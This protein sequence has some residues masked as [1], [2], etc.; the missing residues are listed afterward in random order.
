MTPRQLRTFISILLGAL[1]TLTA[2]SDG[3]GNGPGGAPLAPLTLELPAVGT[4]PPGMVNG[5]TSS[6]AMFN[7]ELPEDSL[8]SDQITLRVIDSAGNVVTL[9]ANGIDGGG[10]IS[11]GPADLSGLTDGSLSVTAMVERGGSSSGETPL[12]DIELD[13]LPPLAPDSLAIPSI[14]GVP[15]DVVATPNL[16]QVAVEMGRTGAFAGDE[17]FR[18]QFSDGVNI[19]TI[20]LFGPATPGAISLT[21]PVG[22]LSSL[23]DGLI[24]VE[25]T[26]SDDA[27]NTVVVNK[28]G[29]IK[30]TQAPAL[31]EAVAIAA[32][33]SNGPNELNATNAGDAE[34]DVTWP[35]AAS[36]DDEVTFTF[37]AGGVSV[38]FGPLS[39]LDGGG[40]QTLGPIDLSGLPDGTVNISYEARDPATNAASGVGTPATKSAGGLI[41]PSSA[42]VAA[43]TDN[44]ADI[45]NAASQNMAAVTVILPAAYDGSEQISVRLSD[46]INPD[47]N[48]GQLSSAPG[49]GQLNF[50]GLDV[51]GL[52][53]GPLALTV[54]VD[55]GAGPVNF[56]GDM[57]QKDT[58]A[59]ALPSAAGLAAG[60]GNAANEINNTNLTN[61]VVN[62]VLD[63]GMTGDE[64]VSLRLQDTGGTILP[65]GPFPIAAGGGSANF[66]PL[67]LSPLGDGSISIEVVVHDPAGNPG[68]FS[69]S[70]ANKSTAGPDAPSAAMVIAG[71]GNAAN[72]INQSNLNS[73]QVAVTLPATTQATDII[74]VTLSD[75]VA[76]AS[77][78]PVNSPGSPGAFTIG[79]IDSTGLQDG[80]IA[81]MVTIDDGA[82][83]VTGFTGTTAT[84]DATGPTAPL[85]AFV[86]ASTSNP[87]NFINLATQAA[88]R[89]D[90]FLDS[91]LTASDTVALTLSDGAITIGPFTQNAL[92]GGGILSFTGIDATTLTPG[93]VSLGIVLADAGA[94]ETPAMGSPAT[95]DIVA[96][97]APT[98]SFVAAGTD[99]PQDFVN[100]ANEGMTSIEVQIPAS[101]VGGEMVSLAINDGINP[102]VTTLEVSAPA[103][104]TTMLFSG[105]DLS[106]LNDGSLT[107]VFQGRDGAGNLASF[108]GTPATKDTAAPDAPSAL[109]VAAGAQNGASIINAFNEPSTTLDITWPA[110][111][112]GD[113]TANVILSSDGGGSLNFGTPVPAGGGTA[114]IGPFAS[115]PL[116]DGNVSLTIEITDPAGNLTSFTG[117]PALK[118][119]APATDPLT[120]GVSAGPQNP[121]NFIN[122][123]TRN[124]VAV[125]VVL[126]ASAEAT[127]SVTVTL[128]DSAMTPTAVTAAQNP[129]AGGGTLSFAGIDASGLIDGSCAVNVR[130]VD[131][132][133]NVTDYVG[134]PAL[135]DTAA[136]T[137]ASGANVAAT[138]N[139]PIHFVN[140]T[141]EAAV[142]AEAAL[143]GDLVGDETVT[144]IFDDG[145]NPA[146]T[147]GGF[148]ASAGGGTQ[149]E[150]A[151][152][153]VA[154]DEGAIQVTVVITDPAGNATPFFGTSAT[155]DVSA[156]LVA[157]ASNIP[158]SVQNPLNVVNDNIDGGVSFDVVWDNSMIGD[159]SAT[160]TVTSDGGAGSATLGPVTPPAN[161]GPQTIGP[162]DLSALPDGNLTIAYAIED[163]A[164]NSTPFNASPAAKDTTAPDDPTAANVIAGVSNPVHFINIASESSATVEVSLGAGAVAT[165]LIAVSLIDGGMTATP[166][167]ATQNA[168]SGGGSLSFGPI[169]TITLADGPVTVSVQLE[170][171]NGNVKTFN[172][173]TATKDTGLPASIDASVIAATSDNPEGFINLTTVAGVSVS[174]DVPASY[175]SADTIRVRLDDG[176]NQTSFT[177]TQSPTGGASETLTFPG[178][179]ASGLNDGTGNINIAVEVVEASG[180]TL[181]FSGSSGSKD[182]VLPDSPVAFGV[183]AGAMN[184]ADFINSN[185]EGATILSVTWG[186]AQETDETASV[187]LSSSGGG[188]NAT[189]PTLMPASAGG[190]EDFAGFVTSGLGDG[191]VTL[192]M[193]ITDPAGN[194]RSVT[195]TPATK[196]ATA[197]DDPSVA[198]VAMTANNAQDLITP[199]SVSLVTVDVTVPNTAV[200]TDSIVVVL[201]DGSASTAATAPQSPTG[202]VAQTLSFGPIDATGLADG[203]V[204]VIVQLT[205]QNQN[206]NAFTGTP[207]VKAVNP[208]AAVTAARVAATMGVNPLDWINDASQNSFAIDVS[209]PASYTGTEDIVVTISDGSNSIT[210]GT[211]QPSGGGT[212][213]TFA[214]LDAAAATP[215]A[216]NDSLA[217]TINVQITDSAGNVTNSGPFAAM[218]DTVNPPLPASFGVA[219]GAQNAINFIN[220]ENVG[221]TVLAVTWDG[222]QETSDSAVFTL[223]SDGGGMVTS[224]AFNPSAAG[225]SDNL[226]GFDTSGLTDSSAGGVAL[227]V[228]VT[229]LAGNTATA[230]GTAATKDVAPPAT[231]VSV[232]VTAGANNAQNVINPTNETAV[233][234]EIVFGGSTV[235][236]DTYVATLTDPAMATSSTASTNAPGMASTISPATLNVAA[237]GDNLADGDLAI[238]ITLTDL[239]GNS[240]TYSFG[241]ALKDTVAPSPVTAAAISAGMSNPAGFA[242]LAST[243]SV[244]VEVDTPA[245]YTG[246][247]T[248]SLVIEDSMSN[249]TS[250]ATSS[251]N[252]GAETITFTGIDASGLVDGALTLRVDVVDSAGNA[253]TQFTGAGTKDVVP[254]HLL[255][256]SLPFTASTPTNVVLNDNAMSAVLQADWGS[257]S[258]AADTYEVELDDSTLQSTFGPT[259]A[260][261]GAGSTTQSSLDLSA[262]TDGLIAVT[263]DASDAAGNTAQVTATLRKY[264]SGA[265]AR[266]IFAVNRDDDTVTSYLIEATTGS[267][268]STGFALTGD[269]PVDIAIAESLGFAFVAN[270]AD[271]NVSAF[272]IDVDN[273]V[274]LPV[275]GSPFGVGDA[276]IALATDIGGRFLYVANAGD[277]DLTIYSVNGATGALESATT[278]SLGGVPSDV[279]VDPSGLFLYVAMPGNITSFEIDQISGLLSN[280]VTLPIGSGELHLGVH[281]SGQWVYATETANDM[282]HALEVNMTTGALAAIASGSAVATGDEPVGVALTADGLRAY[283]TDRADG[284]I[285]MY[286]VNGATGALTPTSNSPA[287]AA[288]SSAPSAIAVDVNTGWA[289][290]AARDSNAL[291]LFEIDGSG[292][293]GAGKLWPSHTAPIAIAFCHGDSSVSFELLNAYVAN[294]ASG[295]VSQVDVDDLNGTLNPLT[296]ELVSVGSQPRGIVLDP[297]GA[298]A[299]VVNR[300]DDNVARLSINGATGALT[301]QENSAIPTNAGGSP[302]RNPESITMS[303]TGRHLFVTSR[304]TS[305]VVPFVV[306]ASTGALSAGTPVSVTGTVPVKSAV[307]PTGKFLYVLEDNAVEAFSVD[308]STGALSSVDFEGSLFSASNVAVHPNG[309]FLYVLTEFFGVKIFDID[310]AT[311]GLTY[312]GSGDDAATGTA[313]ISIAISPDGDAA[314][315]VNRGDQN[316]SSYTVDP[317]TG[318][319]TPVG[320]PANAPVG[321]DARE[322]FID[323]L[324]RYAYVTDFASSGAGTVYL[325]DISGTGELVPNA[326]QASQNLTGL[327]S[328]AIAFRVQVN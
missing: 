82:G 275:S 246:V 6:S 248:L 111:L 25:I 190:S 33:P 276:P 179:D 26:V 123:T 153:L 272:S 31:P 244:S 107:I 233:Q 2:C 327:G 165:D 220:L 242:N 127:D 236:T 50:S 3:G 292:E 306:N 159:E 146:I 299:Y 198:R 109:G 238:S 28:T 35:A 215:S 131:V 323:P 13:T 42:E 79:G 266:K 278:E 157:S 43:G 170:D 158:S 162:F 90:V 76:T 307:S 263:A 264:T 102:L 98:A 209:I 132:N 297:L 89:V 207:A 65:F 269:N 321:T 193:T 91:S 310:P 115:T 138:G 288:T 52:N 59:P 152:N 308:L 250:A 45:V 283:V 58:V 41:G 203:S 282:V 137:A 202:G 121:A 267:L 48:S 175:G 133:G 227:A 218:K 86:A 36:A 182:T 21:S 99:N 145:S 164:G 311:G 262:F 301:F 161:G 314:W 103:G 226:S 15:I 125:E 174:V 46:G 106:S 177:S 265:F 134:T 75:G 142:V 305:E 63:P 68:S 176:G 112:A 247:E 315:V 258:D 128:V 295:E 30:D 150:S 199:A 4:A 83:G 240:A 37:L 85:A 277:S 319:F 147:S 84:K 210:T 259:N 212:T 66:G 22:D 71:A 225:A 40:S 191:N 149:S 169:D 20:P 119:V 92:N 274:L 27:G 192:T 96:P 251:T 245:N 284:T 55:A 1:L 216:L 281:P 18:I 286:D 237:G 70:P 57:A 322:I 155:K 144:F 214:G 148:T 217:L 61:A 11:V 17:N 196:D 156:P 211:Q 19:V 195:G 185:N 318:L 328:D 279:V 101:Y 313:A 44:P 229:D 124:G 304:D 213:L 126:G 261:A 78:A 232:I 208:P 77:S 7:L 69:G 105:I 228:T 180:N 122:A 312:K 23:S 189:S 291:E 167:T 243:G 324:A 110:T 221:S 39:P 108:N 187:E 160:I 205:D 273:G 47:V 141:T 67:D 163:P 200:S 135:L 88:V 317:A 326:T 166:L 120:A 204:Q 224:P 206:T 104:P 24:D 296:T 194:E 316:V 73:T 139:N 118:D 293:L 181:T 290:S 16:S 130:I 249:T 235:A 114:T 289:V 303:P 154:L 72:E 234:L 129:V 116:S 5:Q 80:Q 168:I 201:S 253:G 172:G 34:L 239:N 178:V 62:V 270:E 230:N 74:T 219:S 151:I 32:G 255:R 287:T 9:L 38:V 54:F 10:M 94:N 197:P 173:V 223:T 188:G 256:V 257:M 29:V 184:A 81:V 254:P 113:E 320:T 53:D 171:Q 294:Q 117:T 14:A 140:G 97:A 186:A 260:N 298:N 231:P 60:P 100:S 51:S 183:K 8:S 136:P 87:Q 12:G 268:Y 64:T 222:S 325:F 241:T 49:G 300:G 302:P 280:G 252:G 271:D 95:K 56:S 143:P 309:K 285:S 93:P